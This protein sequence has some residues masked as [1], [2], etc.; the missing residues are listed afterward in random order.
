MF[1]VSMPAGTRRCA[2]QSAAAGGLVSAIKEQESYMND[3]KR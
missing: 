2:K 3:F 1:A